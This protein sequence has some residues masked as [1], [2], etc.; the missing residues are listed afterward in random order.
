MKI[1]KYRKM[2]GNKYEVVVDGVSYKM[3]DDVIVHSELLRK[4]NI[5]S[6]E[7][8]KIIKYNDSLEAY[9]KAISYIQKKLRTE[10]EI[11]KYLGK[12]YDDCVIRET[13]NKLKN[14]GYLNREAYIKS[15]MS[16]QVYLG[17]NGPDKIKRDLLQLGFNEEEIDKIREEYDD[18]VWLDK[19]NKIID[20]KLLINHK[21]SEN[22][23]KEK[24][25]YD[26]SN[27]GYPRWMI[28]DVLDGKK[29]VVNDDVI[30]KEYDKLYRKYSKKYSDKEL[31]YQLKMRLLQKGFTSEEI[32]NLRK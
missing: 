2:A 28:E 9:Y 15:Y 31:D 5:N 3:Y 1:D 24:I 13:I 14:E 27:M 29:I 30:I 12:N 23:L 18:K 32:E 8:N 4:K 25:V 26:L 11:E 20:K 19:L 21:Y 16:D 6:D 22:K 10:K 7:F 17:S